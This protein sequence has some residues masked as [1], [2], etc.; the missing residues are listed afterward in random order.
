MIPYDKA[1][2]SRQTDSLASRHKEDLLVKV[3]GGY[4]KTLDG[5]RAIAVLGVLIT[6]A[7]HRVFAVEG[8][9]PNEFWFAA[10]R[11]GAYGVDI[12]FGISGFLIC[13]RLLQEE[14]RNGSINLKNFY[15]RRVFRILPPYYLYLLV[16]VCLSLFQV[17][18]VGFWETISCVFFFR[19]YLPKELVM[20]HYTGHLWSLSVEEHFYLIL[21][22]I[23][24]FMN[25]M[26]SMMFVVGFALLVGAWRVIEFRLGLVG[27]VIPGVGF[28]DRSDIAFD[29]LLWGAVLAHVVRIE[30]ARQLI[31]KWLNPVG[32]TTITLLCIFAVV[33]SVP[34]AHFWKSLLIP[35]IIYGTIAHSEGPVGKF[36]ESKPMLWIGRRSYGIY[37]WQSLFLV[38]ADVVDPPF[39]YFQLLPLNLIPIFVIVAFS[40]DYIEKPLMRMG[41]NFTAKPANEKVSLK[42]SA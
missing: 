17:L 31:E 20:G 33:L 39:G 6:H 8:S 27:Q 36:L 7:F 1:L 22:F 9:L 42:N 37:V 21:P 11:Y 10:T 3:E 16:V 14:D 24:V 34:L 40:Y 15:I 4:Y 35:L 12:F 13:S 41:R 38:A 29:G 28:F 18:E 25:R 30:K 2:L 19:N 23:L 26:K 5:W 32:W